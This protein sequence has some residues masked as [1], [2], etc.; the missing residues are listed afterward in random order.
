MAASLRRTSGVAF[1]LVTIVLL[2]V[3]ALGYRTVRRSNDANQS[4]AHT[5]QAL[6]ALENVLTTV[7]DA[8]TATRGYGG[9]RLRRYLEPFNRAMTKVDPSIDSLAALTV[10]HPGQQQP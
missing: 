4:V 6:T 1:G 2:V 9:T 5:Y 3:S 7:V 8:E 10:D